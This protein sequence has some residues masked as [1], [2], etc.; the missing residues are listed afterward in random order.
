MGHDKIFCKSAKVFDMFSK[1]IYV[2]ISDFI[3]S[4]FISKYEIKINYY[5]FLNKTT[6]CNHVMRYGMYVY[7]KIWM[8]KQDCFIKQLTN[9]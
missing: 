2:N 3:W 9:W 7:F 5:R 1:T 6:W 4:D 8:V